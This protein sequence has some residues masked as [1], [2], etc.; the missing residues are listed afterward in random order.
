[1]PPIEYVYM[2][3]VRLNM[4]IPKIY[5]KSEGEKTTALLKDRRRRS[6]GGGE[7]NGSQSKFLYKNWSMSQ[8]QILKPKPC[9][10]VMNT[11][12]NS[13]EMIPSKL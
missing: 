9:K 2:P 13:I 1:V 3:E 4:G 6:E 5:E 8:V 10:E 7:V 11:P 12:T